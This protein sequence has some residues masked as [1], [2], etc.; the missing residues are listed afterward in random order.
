MM[1]ALS[2]GGSHAL[3]RHLAMNY[4]RLLTGSHK[5]DPFGW[6]VSLKHCKKLL[7]AM[8]C[9]NK[10]SYEII[11]GASLIISERSLRFKRRTGSSKILS[12]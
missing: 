6:R 3:I 5:D 12:H 7:H 8:N 11:V 1:Q 4:K 2:V 9:T 10:T